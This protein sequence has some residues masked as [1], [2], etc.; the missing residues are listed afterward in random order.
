MLEK[1]N[2]ELRDARNREQLDINM[3]SVVTVSGFGSRILCI[4]AIAPTENQY[5]HEN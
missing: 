2:V 3:V 4:N 1:S 5:G